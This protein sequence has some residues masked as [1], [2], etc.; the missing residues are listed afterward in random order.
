MQIYLQNLQV[1]FTYQGNRVN[2]KVTEAIFLL[3]RWCQVKCFCDQYVREWSER[4]SCLL[5]TICRKRDWSISLSL[6]LST[7]LA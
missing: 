5:K 2:L 1:M 7:K 6:L 3:I 4:Q